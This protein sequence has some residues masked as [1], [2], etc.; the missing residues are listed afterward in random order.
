MNDFD[1][2]LDDSLR[3]IKSG[4]ATADECL[5]HHPEYSAQLK[6]LLQTAGRLERGRELT[7]TEAYRVRAREQLAAHMKA[8]PRRNR[9][10]PPLIWTIAISLAV[11]MVAFFVTGTALAQGA[12][13]GQ[14]L[15]EWKLSSEQIWRNS[16]SDRL[17]VDLQL[18]DRR[19][20]EITSVSGDKTAEARA[21]A[22]YQEV[23][24]RLKTENDSKNNDRVLM[25]L[26]SNQQRLSAAGIN[27]PELDTHTTP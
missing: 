16:S 14:P 20:Y 23:L 9:R 1:Q 11:L 27:I 26:K 15:Y 7:P 17:S 24:T 10:K 19:I 6:P 4:T 13:P 5:A 25:T 18:A 21:L 22:G 8:Q 2:V 12:L 3:Q